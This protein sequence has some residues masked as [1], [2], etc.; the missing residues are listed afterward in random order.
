MSEPHSP[1]ALRRMSP[2]DWDTYR[3]LVS[4]WYITDGQTVPWIIKELQETRHGFKV[5]QYELKDRIAAWGL[6]KNLTRREQECVVAQ[7]KRKKSEVVPSTLEYTFAGQDLSERRLKR[8]ENRFDR[9][10]MAWGRRTREYLLQSNSGHLGFGS[11]SIDKLAESFSRLMPESREDENMDRARSLIR[12]RG[13]LDMEILKVVLF[14]LS[15]N[16]VGMKDYEHIVRL[17]ERLGL[18]RPSII[19]ALFS[20]AMNDLTIAAILDKLFIASCKTSSLELMRVLVQ[21]NRVVKN[22]QLMPVLAFDLMPALVVSAKKQDIGSAKA[23]MAVPSQSIITHNWDTSFHREDREF[24]MGIIMCKDHQFTSSLVELI[25]HKIEFRQSFMDHLLFLAL[26]TGNISLALKSVEYGADTDA[27]MNTPLFSL[28]QDASWNKSPGRTVKFNSRIRILDYHT[29]YTACIVPFCYGPGLLVPLGHKEIAMRTYEQMVTSLGPPWAMQT[30]EK[31]AHIDVLIS[32]AFFGCCSILDK[33]TSGPGDLN[34]T[35]NRGMSPLI[36]A[37][38]GG[39]VDTCRCLLK[40]GADPNFTHSNPQKSGCSHVEPVAGRFPAALHHAIFSGHQQMV[41]LLIEF[42]ADVNQ[43]CDHSTMHDCPW[44]YRECWW[45]VGNLVLDRFHI[46]GFICSMDTKAISALHI[47]TKRGYLGDRL[48]GRMIVTE[49]ASGCDYVEIS[50]LLLQSGAHVGYL[51]LHLAIEFGSNCLVEELLSKFI[52]VEHLDAPLKDK[53]PF[54]VA[55]QTKNGP[56]CETLLTAGF[57]VDTKPENLSLAV[58]GGSERVLR[59]LLGIL[60]ATCSLC[61][62]E[63]T[64]ALQVALESGFLDAA[65]ILMKEG[66][67]L[68]PNWWRYPFGTYQADSLLSTLEQFDATRGVMMN[69]V[70]QDGWSVLEAAMQ[71]PHPIVADIALNHFPRAYDSG[72]LLARLCRALGASD[73]STDAPLD[74]LIKRRKTAQEAD[75]TPI[76]EN[77]A[78]A[79]AAYF[80]KNDLLSALLERPQPQALALVPGPTLWDKIDDPSRP[81]LAWPEDT[82]CNRANCSCNMVLIAAIRWHEP[83]LIIRKLLNTLRNYKLELCIWESCPHYVK[84][85]IDEGCLQTVKLLTD[86]EEDVGNL[87]YDTTLSDRYWFDGPK[88][89]LQ[90]AIYAHRASDEMAYY[91]IEKGADVKAPAH[92]DSGLSSLQLAAMQGKIALARFLVKQGAQ[93]N[94]PRAHLLGRTSLEAAAEAGRLDMVQ[95]LLNEGAEIE[96]KGRVQYIRAMKLARAKGHAAVEQLLRRQ[97]GRDLRDEI[98]ETQGNIVCTFRLPVDT[99]DHRREP[100]IYTRLKVFLHPDEATFEER[101]NVRQWS[102]ANG[103]KPPLDAELELLSNEELELP[104]WD[105]M[106]MLAMI[107]DNDRVI[108]RRARASIDQHPS[109]TSDLRLRYVFATEVEIIRRNLRPTTPSPEYLSSSD[110]GEYDDSSISCSDDETS[111]VPSHEEGIQE[112]ENHPAQEVTGCMWPGPP[113]GDGGRGGLVAERGREPLAAVPYVQGLQPGHLAGGGGGPLEDLGGG[114]ESVDAG[115]EDLRRQDKRLQAGPRPR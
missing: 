51:E 33:C 47:A 16:F 46:D 70:P 21:E 103:F 92:P 115:D 44:T 67:Q 72:A 18:G 68:P 4:R 39:S 61:T 80:H 107:L 88:T 102:I 81:E 100:T 93:I 60:K 86:H 95:F 62:S 25:I 69:Q 13:E 27:Q 84:F 35:N 11:S 104:L 65:S 41:N 52:S 101:R 54:Q 55:I 48:N 10:T 9:P 23:I 3:D 29:V 82:P 32:A 59:C 34:R 53:T 22:G 78:I 64:K 28:L 114:A 63:L 40:L 77:A 2:T 56:V 97:R 7:R 1:A 108:M 99:F 19:R 43:L 74:E 50:R 6:R 12:T 113:P 15:N 24:W 79:L 91:L 31:S 30:R 73:S 37:V 66:A 89:A 106:N 75:L 26:Q 17:V 87:Y 36:A 14:R 38:L 49:E 57:R 8:L 111:I 85:M 71:N 105:R 76:L 94:E 20:V 58:E 96:G 112:T 42:K 83:T 90:L 5:A 98:L 45:C 109:R 110:E